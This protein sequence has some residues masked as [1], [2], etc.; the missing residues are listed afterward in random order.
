MKNNFK[1]NQS[2]F[3]SYCLYPNIHFEIQTPSEK[4]ILILRA[5]PV[6]QLFWIFNSFIFFILLIVLNFITPSFLNFNQII[7]INIFGLIIIFSYLWFNFLNWFFNVGVITTERILDI[8][9]HMALYKEVTA[10]RLNRIEDITSKTGGYLASF[11]D[12]GNIFIQTAGTEANIEFFNVP[13]PAKVVQIING[14]LGKNHG[15]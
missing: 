7:F 14:L 9:F 8:D 6:T 10:S 5:H 15:P 2:L 13:H 3:Y 11:F 4:V 12:F 1:T